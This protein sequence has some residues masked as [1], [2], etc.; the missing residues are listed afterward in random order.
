[1]LSYVLWAL[2]ALGILYEGIAIGRRKVLERKLT[3]EFVARYMEDI[4][5]Q[6]AETN[7]NLEKGI[8]P[9]GY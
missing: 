6:V 2:F 3:D 8:L 7:A 9:P 1:M 4:K 5:R